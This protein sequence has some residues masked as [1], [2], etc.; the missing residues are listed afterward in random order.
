MGD[1]I[2]IPSDIKIEA[3]TKSITRNGRKIKKPISNAVF[4]SD[5]INAG[6][7]IDIGMDFLS[8]NGPLSD[9]SANKFSVSILVLETMNSFIMSNPCDRA[10]FI[11]ILPSK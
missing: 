8:S 6:S 7:T 11:S 4:S 1:N 5:V 10:K 9:I 3:I 2:I